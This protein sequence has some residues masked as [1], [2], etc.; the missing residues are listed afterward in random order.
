MLFLLLLYGKLLFLSEHVQRVEEG[1]YSN[2]HSNDD[3]IQNSVDEGVLIFLQCRKCVRNASE[4]V[5]E[6][7]TF[8]VIVAVIKAIVVV[9]QIG[10]QQRTKFEI[11][12][13]N[14]N[15]TVEMLVIVII[16]VVVDDV[17]VVGKAWFPVLLQ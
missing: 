9:T 11:Q 6:I 5:V 15:M 4:M 16:V 13:T 8:V 7:L 17:D 14:I 10:E 1:L 12:A 2:R 3:I